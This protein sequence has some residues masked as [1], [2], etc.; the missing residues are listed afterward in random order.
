[1]ILDIWRPLSTKLY[2]W[3]Y[4]T[5]GS[6]YTSQTS[7]K[8]PLMT[9]SQP[10]H[11]NIPLSNEWGR[12]KRGSRE[13]TNI[14]FWKVTAVLIFWYFQNFIWKRRIKCKYFNL[15]TFREIN[16]IPVETSNTNQ[17]FILDWSASLIFWYHCMW[18]WGIC[19][20]CS[21]N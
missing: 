6:P 21:P 15:N 13:L 4:D 3:R 16:R 18:H 2:N 5:L 20:F 17:Y 12:A 7:Y 1:M 10:K 14:I 9:P 8:R 19:D 11:K